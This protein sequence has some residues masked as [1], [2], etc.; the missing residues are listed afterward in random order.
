MKGYIV[1]SS[2][3]KYLVCAPTDEEGVDYKAA[4]TCNTVES[5]RTL[6]SDFNASE[7]LRLEERR[8]V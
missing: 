3:G 6:A 2:Q 1:V 7:N 4:I 5:A 8:K